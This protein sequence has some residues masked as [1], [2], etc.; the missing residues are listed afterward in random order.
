CRNGH[1]EACRHC[2]ASR[3]KEGPAVPGLGFRGQMAPQPPQGVQGGETPLALALTPVATKVPTGEPL[4]VVN[5][6]RPRRGKPSESGSPVHSVSPTSTRAFV[7]PSAS[8]TPGPDVSFRVPPSSALHSPTRS[9][10]GIGSPPLASKV[11]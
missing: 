7:L 11:S 10:P 5:V 9:T 2:T 3:Q 6:Q 1:R 8:V 4:D